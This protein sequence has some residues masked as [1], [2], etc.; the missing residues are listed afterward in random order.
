MAN[1]FICLRSFMPNINCIIKV[2]DAATG[3]TDTD[4]IETKICR[5]YSLGG[6]HRTIVTTLPCSDTA[7]PM[8]GNFNFAF[9]LPCILNETVLNKLCILHMLEY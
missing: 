8:Q 5:H 7:L 6:S 9:S 4:T 1:A 2:S 3:P